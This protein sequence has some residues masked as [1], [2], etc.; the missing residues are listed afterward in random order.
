MF[1]PSILSPNR[2]FQLPTVNGVVFLHLVLTA[3]FIVLFAVIYFGFA[4]KKGGSLAST[5]LQITKSELGKSLLLGFVVF[6][7][8]YLAVSV[9]TYFF[10][11]DVGFF[12]FTFKPMPDFKWSHFLR[13]LPF[14]FEYYLAAGVLLNA[15]TRINKQ[16]EWLNTALIVF[17]SGGGLA[18][19]QI[20]DYGTLG[21]TGLRGVPTVPGTGMPNTLSGIFMFGLL[22]IVPITGLVARVFYKKTGRVWVGSILNALLVTFYVTCTA[23]VAMIR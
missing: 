6:L 12:K 4:K 5:G 18:L 22:F 3:F 16:K 20:Y 13:Y 17:I 8:V 21:L 9:C 2:Y 15:V 1:V 19:H 7:L 11:V 14:F 10:H 23:T